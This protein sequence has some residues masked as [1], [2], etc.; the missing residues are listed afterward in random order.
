MSLADKE[1]IQHNILLAKEQV[2]NKL[3]LNRIKNKS[4]R[5]HSRIENALVSYND[6]IIKLLKTE[7]LKTSIRKHKQQ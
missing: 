3:I 1:I 5:E 7:S 2:R 6:E 4:F